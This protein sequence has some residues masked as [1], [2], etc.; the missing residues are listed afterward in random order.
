MVPFDFS[1]RGSLLRLRPEARWSTPG[2]S[3]A[4]GL[5]RCGG[6][7][8]SHL[9][10]APVQHL[11]GDSCQMPCRPES[12]GGRSVSGRAP[13]FLGSV[14]DD[15]P[16][17]MPCGGITFVRLVGQTGRA[18]FQTE[19]ALL[20]DLGSPSD[21]CAVPGGSTDAPLTVSTSLFRPLTGLRPS[22]R[23]DSQTT[24]SDGPMVLPDSHPGR[25]RRPFWFLPDGRA[26]GVA[27][28][29]SRPEAASP[30]ANPR[31]VHD[32]KAESR[33]RGARRPREPRPRNQVRCAGK[34]C[35]LHRGRTRSAPCMGH[36]L[37]G[38]QQRRAR[39]TSSTSASADGRRIG[40]DR[41]VAPRRPGAARGRR[42]VGRRPRLERGARSLR[43]QTSG[44]G[45]RSVV[46]QVEPDDLEHRRPDKLPDPGG[47]RRKLEAGTIRRSGA[48]PGGA[49]GRPGWP[50]RSVLAGA[51]RE[52]SQPKPRRLSTRPSGAVPRAPAAR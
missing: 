30:R 13:A 14:V 33:A 50:V 29:S 15:A 52:I 22:D 46:G 47:V 37:G 23:T 21:G 3:D 44:A 7:P 19:Y 12:G 20:L 31:R 17:G 27:R 9:R 40:A 16:G 1:R 36:P 8:S 41:L 49:A 42:I 39:G 5:H 34:T 26:G 45:E 51:A 48:D 6:S 24:A 10:Q 4:A 11:A 43:H 32:A 35:S 28:P 25:A 38:N 2:R 18:L